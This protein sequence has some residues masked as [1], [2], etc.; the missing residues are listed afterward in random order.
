MKALLTR[1]KSF[2]RM[3]NNKGFKIIV[4]SAILCY[5][6]TSIFAQKE[7]SF[8]P[9]DV[10]LEWQLVQ[11]N[12]QSKPQFLS[13]ITITNKSMHGLPSS[14]WRLYFN[15]RYHG[16]HLNSITPHFKIEQ[17]NGE[18]FFI[19]PTK[20]FKGLKPNQAAR[21]EYIGTGRIANYNDLPSGLFWVRDNDK[22]TAIPAS[23][24]T[25]NHS[26]LH[27]TLPQLDAAKIFRENQAIE[28]IPESQLPK[29]FPTPVE[30]NELSGHFVFG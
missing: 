27:D 24:L 22:E 7:N 28:E 29:I 3:A 12:Y 11:N 15:L 14:G 4:V 1:R 17:V 5:C 26:F 25:I 21:I 23:D 18:L 30:Y 6:H 2:A 9:K 8:T 20:E 13:S 10:H 16:F 19:A